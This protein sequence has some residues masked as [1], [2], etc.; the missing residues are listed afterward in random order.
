MLSEFA[1]AALEL[2]Q[3]WLVN[4]HS[5]ESVKETIMTAIGTTPDDRRRRMAAM[6]AYLSEH[7]VARWAREF[8]EAL[9]DTRS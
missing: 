2:P 1:G 4:P 6:R 3:A 5:L 9:E 8:L 7:D